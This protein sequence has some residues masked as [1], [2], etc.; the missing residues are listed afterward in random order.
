MKACCGD[1]PASVAFEA[2]DLPTPAGWKSLF[3]QVALSWVGTPYKHHGQKKGPSGGVDCVT[4]LIGVY[5]EVGVIPF[6]EPPYYS[7]I[8]AYHRVGERYINEVLKYAQPTGAPWMVGDLFLFKMPFAMSCGHSAVYVGNGQ[9][10]HALW[11]QHRPGRIAG[12]GTVTIN[13]VRENLFRRGLKAAY[14]HPD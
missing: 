3:R 6:F 12:A 5:S 11:G 9:I 2:P 13:S 14:R 10:V 1:V 7:P 4:F 8:E